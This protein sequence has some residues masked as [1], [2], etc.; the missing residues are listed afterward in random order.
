MLELIFLF[1]MIGYFAQTVLFIIGAKKKFYRI[2]D[3]KLP[4]A[5]IIVAARNEE[6]NILRTLE[7]LEKLDYPDGKLQILI[8][9]DQSTDAT[10]KIIDDFIKD[11][12]HFKKDNNRRA[13]HKTD[14][15]DAH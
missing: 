7:S 12:P 2:T 5:T 4:T 6:D 9:D 1:I 8:V 15:K 10:G 14:R 3:D 11:K 13:S